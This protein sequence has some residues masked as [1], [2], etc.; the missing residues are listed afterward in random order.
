MAEGIQVSTQVLVDTACKLRNI[1]ATLYEKLEQ[2]NIAMNSLE[3]T[4]NSDAA[5]DI[6]EAMNALRPNFE[7]YEEI[8]ASYAKFLENTAET[9]ETTESAIQNNAQQFK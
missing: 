2:I 8:V 4:W 5:R 7:R 1:N 9:Y 6:R 3:S